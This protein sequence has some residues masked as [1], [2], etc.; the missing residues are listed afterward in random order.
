MEAESRD[1]EDEQEDAQ[2]AGAAETALVPAGTPWI[3]AWAADPRHPVSIWLRLQTRGMTTYGYRQ[4]ASMFAAWLARNSEHDIIHAT[5]E[6]LLEYRSYLSMVPWRGDQVRLSSTIRSHIDRLRSLYSFLVAERHIT[7][8]PTTKL[9][10]G[11]ADDGKLKL[12]W[13]YEQV[14]LFWHAIDQEIRH[15]T[16]GGYASMRTRALRDKAIFAL[17][18]RNGLRVSE[19]AGANIRHLVMEHGEPVLHLREDDGKEH[20]KGGHAR[21]AVLMPKTF[22]AIQAYMDARGFE[23]AAAVLAARDQP[24]FLRTRDSGRPNKAGVQKK[25]QEGDDGRISRFGVRDRMR[26]Y[27]A[28]AGIPMEQ[29]HPHAARRTFVTT[30]IRAKVP[31]PEIADDT[32]HRSLDMLLVYWAHNRQIE[33]AAARQIEY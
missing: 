2:E 8:S 14:I 4:S 3:E 32:G 17:L 10:V 18:F 33:N 27:G 31:L 19:A 25:M 16:E 20:V 12:A 21:R 28:L 29:C 6:D 5:L 30:L 22:Q 7:H 24:L 26:R 11:Q 15:A 13:E 23:S 1:F 9:K